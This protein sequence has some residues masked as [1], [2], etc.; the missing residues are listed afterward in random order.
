MTE[1]I[2]YGAGH[3]GV[4]VLRHL[5]APADRG[6][7]G[8]ID[9]GR[10]QEW[11]DKAGYAV[12]TSWS[13]KYAVT[14]YIGHVNFSRPVRVGDLVETTARLVSTGRSSMHIEVTV[15]SGD[16]REA[17][18]S[19]AARCYITFVAVDDERRPVPVPSWVPNS[20]EQEMAASRV[21]VHNHLRTDIE[22]RVRL[23]SY[24]A[25][26][27]APRVLLRFLAAPSDVNWGGKVHGGIVMRW[28][29]EAAHALV[30]R[31]TGNVEN[32]AVFVGGTHFL[33]PIPI[34]H[35][36]EVEARL[37]HTGTS[38]MHIAVHVRSNDVR[39][40]EML[41]ATQCLTVFVAF[42]G[43]R[44]VPCPSWMPET[45]EDLR[46]DRHAVDLMSIRTGYEDAQGQGSLPLM[47]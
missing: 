10:V 13:G 32:A 5:A 11:I 15:A 23:Q 34:G 6:Y 19:A 42:E 40:D 17:T 2:A 44:V 28:I 24:T 37:I 30:T 26:G 18:L 36:V 8:G 3:V 35:L 20:V 39:G 41:T 16:P 31:W 38:S 7:S 21:A 12:A 27:T 9:A 22:Q 45:D 43:S 46:L 25:E 29:D 1:P 33:R 4:A 14:A 47:P